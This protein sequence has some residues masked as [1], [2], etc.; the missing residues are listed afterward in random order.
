MDK[1]KL[2][3]DLAIETAF[4]LRLQFKLPLRQTEGFIKS[5]FRLMNAGLNN[6]DHT[7][8]SCRNS[9]LKTSLK[10]I[11]KPSGVCHPLQYSES[12]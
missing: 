10:R 2:Y 3:S 11:D 4:T 12:I 6:P 9:A 7:T 5:I 1:P 8:L